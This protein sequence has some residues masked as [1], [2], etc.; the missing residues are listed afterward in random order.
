MEI[1]KELLVKNNIEDALKINNYNKDQALGFVLNP[2]QISVYNVD[3]NE[4]KL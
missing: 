1:I 2:Y 4:Y 3:Q